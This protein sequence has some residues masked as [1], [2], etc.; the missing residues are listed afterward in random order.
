MIDIDSSL[1]DLENY[2]RQTYQS[3]YDIKTI[4]TSAAKDIDISIDA[5]IRNT[6]S[7]LVD[8]GTGMG[9]KEFIDDL[10]VI[11]NSNTFEITTIS[12]RTDYSKSKRE[13][14]PNLLKNAKISKSGTRYKIIPISN[15]NDMI[16]TQRDLSYTQQKMLEINAKDNID[17]FTFHKTPLKPKSSYEAA[18]S[19][20]T[21]TDK[22]NA[23]TQWVIPEKQNNVLNIL[24]D[25]NAAMRVDIENAINSII[26][27]YKEN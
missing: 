10:K 27:K 11:K 13:M 23:S 17:G 12:G 20:R 16:Q 22:Q 21:A 19:F 1:R 15:K 2:L 25:L 4:L 3:S 7:I 5:I 6:L 9:C 24:I 14:L 8:I 26:A 18:S